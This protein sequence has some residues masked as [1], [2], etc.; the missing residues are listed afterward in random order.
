MEEGERDSPANSAL[1]MEP[2]AGL[3]VTTLK[4]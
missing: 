4:S 3:D 1:S 2:D